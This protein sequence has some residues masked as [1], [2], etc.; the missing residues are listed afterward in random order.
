MQ[1]LTFHHTLILLGLGA[2]ILEMVLGVST[3]FD[4][5][6]VGGILIV[7]GALGLAVDSYLLSLIIIILLSLAYIFFFR[8]KL[9][10]RLAV[11]THATNA[12]AL[13]GQK[14][15]VKKQI[16][17]ARPGQIVIDGEVWRA[18]AAESI[19]EGEEV[20]IQSVSGVT[21]RVIR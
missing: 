1:D 13:I 9:Q 6:I 19:D 5:V 4:L 20:I 21:L 7:A 11:T 2:M 14:A 15:L 8:T 12:D 18:E 10:K 16:T 3:G 17:K